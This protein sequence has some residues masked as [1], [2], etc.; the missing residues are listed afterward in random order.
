MPPLLLRQVHRYFSQRGG[1]FRVSGVSE[2]DAE[3]WR[4]Q[5]DVPAGVHGEQA[6]GEAGEEPVAA[7]SS[8]RR[9]IS[10]RRPWLSRNVR[11]S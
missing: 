6:E 3:K 11:L 4:S 10:L 9:L 1:T 5:R 2:R 8:A 7:P